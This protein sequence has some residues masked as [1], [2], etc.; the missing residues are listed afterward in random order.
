VVLA[1]AILSSSFEARNS[2]NKLRQLNFDEFLIR[3]D[4]MVSYEVIVSFRLFCH[5]SQSTVLIKFRLG[6][7]TRSLHGTLSV[8]L[9]F[10][11]FWTNI[12][13][14]FQRNKMILFHS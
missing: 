13:P 4:Q 12:I 8:S 7:D 2:G 5:I 9:N 3:S 14:N 1:S 10:G 11:V 6:I